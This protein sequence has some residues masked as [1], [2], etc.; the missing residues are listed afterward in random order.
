MTGTAEEDDNDGNGTIVLSVINFTVDTNDNILIRG[1]KLDVSGAE[2]PVT[3]TVSIAA[4]MDD[5]VRIDGPNTGAV[6]SDIEVGVAASATA[7]TVRTRGTSG[8]GMTAD[9]TLKE[10]FKGAFMMDNLLEV[11]FSG[12]P[13]GTTLEVEVKSPVTDPRGADEDQ[14]HY[15]PCGYALR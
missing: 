11:R 15:G 3:V 13:D 12:M 1:V 2:G 6:I 8:D 9:L 14:Q 4:A 7:G 5:F 10:S